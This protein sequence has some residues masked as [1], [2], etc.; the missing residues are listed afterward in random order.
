MFT[1]CQSSHIHVHTW[2][3]GWASFPNVRKMK[4]FLFDYRE[5]LLA[6][7]QSAVSPG[8][9]LTLMMSQQSLDHEAGYER[10]VWQAG[11]LWL[12][13]C[14]TAV[15]VCAL[16]HMLLMCVCGSVF[17]SVPTPSYISWGSFSVWVEEEMSFNMCMVFVQ[18]CICKSVKE[19]D[20]K[21]LQTKQQCLEC[22]KDRASKPD[23]AS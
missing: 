12:G 16:S 19:Y 1:Q 2:D 3:T 15:R 10:A 5:E 13:W 7:L 6:L 23:Q 17:I 21:Q 18:V 22:S 14:W 11:G 20:G 8:W 9:C 4:M